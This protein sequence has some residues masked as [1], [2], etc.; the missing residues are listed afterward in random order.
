MQ[1]F[2]FSE[3]NQKTL[4]NLARESIAYYL[5]NRTLIPFTADAPELTRSAG[6]FVTLTEQGN[7]RGCIGMTE[8]RDPLY[9]T[10]RRMAAAAATED[11]RFYP[12]RED[13]LAGVRIEISVLSPL[14]RVQS[15]DEIEQGV[16]GVVVRQG[17][18]SGLFLPQVWEHFKRKEDFMNELCCQKAGLA[19][20]AW[21]DGKA[22]LYVFSVFAFEEK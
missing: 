20:A 15:A 3:K 4:L 17:R 14:R 11:H 8:A 18:C 13:E 19:P 2:T 1:K 6:V 7:L 5:K 22:E 9:E 12:V 21:K 10:V 16:H